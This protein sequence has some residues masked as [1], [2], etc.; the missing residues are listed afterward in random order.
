MMDREET[1][2]KRSPLVVRDA[3]LNAYLTAAKVDTVTQVNRS[4]AASLLE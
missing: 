1:R 3:A 2:M 4:S